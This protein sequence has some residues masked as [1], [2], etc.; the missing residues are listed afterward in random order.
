M[1]AVAL[2]STFATLIGFSM[3]LYG[4]CKWYIDAARNDCPS[5]LK[6]ILIETASLKATLEAVQ[7]ILKLSDDRKKDEERLERQIG[8]PLRDCQ[9]CIQGLLELV[10]KPM[11]E[12]TNRTRD[13]MKLI[14]NA[15]A[16]GLKK[17]DECDTLLK[18]LRAHKA[19][20]NLGLTTE[21]SHDVRQIGNDVKEVKSAVSS[22]QARLNDAEKREMYKWLARVNPSTNHNA[23]DV[24]QM[25]GTGTW[26]TDAD[27]DFQEWLSGS[28]N[29]RFLW[30]YGIPGAGKTLLACSMIKKVQSIARA[31]KSKGAAYYYCYH[32]RS[33]DEDEAVLFL[34]WILSQLCR[35]ADYIPDILGH[36]FKSGDDP[37]PKDLLLGLEAVLAHFST[38]YVVLDALDEAKPPANLAKTLAILG[39]NHE[40]YGKLRLAVTS[41]EHQDIATAFSGLAVHIDLSTNK[42]VKQEIEQY[43]KTT[44][45][46]PKYS[47][48]GDSLRAEAAALIPMKAQ[49]M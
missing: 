28:V 9:K 34:M 48:W 42:Y 43:V 22:V 15:L 12:N 26:L 32:S 30:M 40:K 1:E 23:A 35:A 20:L 8:R 46:G 37:S 2:A 7:D 36:L 33:R 10:P 44:L 17:K 39:S 13:K 24:L 21:L 11:K 16:W 45:K 14:A 3:Q 41:R 6:L 31:D 18:N 27:E 4:T 19:T 25:D 5:D 47:A 29:S 38:A 49:G